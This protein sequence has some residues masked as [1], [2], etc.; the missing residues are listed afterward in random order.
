MEHGVQ[1]FMSQAT[2]FNC[3][4]GFLGTSKGGLKFDE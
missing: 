3:R 2:P 1:L 4:L